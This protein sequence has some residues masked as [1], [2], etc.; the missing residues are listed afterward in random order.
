MNTPAA[1]SQQG[2]LFGHPSGLFTLFFAEMWERFSYYGMRALLILYMIK[3]FLGYGDTEAYAIY[4]AYTALVYMT[5]FFGGMIADRLIGQ[6]KAVVLGGAL[7]AA[8]HLFMRF[9]NET[10][11]F[12]ALALL[13]L[14]NGFFKPNISTIVGSLYPKGSAKRDSGFT[15]FY[16][17]INLGAAMSPLLC[18]YIGE[19]YGWHQ[20]FGLATFGMLIGLAVF[21]LP[22]LWS[23]ILIMLTSLVTAGMLFYFHADD[24]AS[25][26]INFSVAT[27]LLV[28]GVIATLAL[29]RGG[30]PKDAGLPAD[31]E[32]L[33]KPALLG[34]PAEWSVYIGTLALVPVFTLLVWGFA[35]F[36]SSTEERSLTNDDIGTAVDIA[37]EDRLSLAKG[38]L[39][40]GT[41]IS[42]EK[43]RNLEGHLLELDKI[44]I[45]KGLLDFK[46][47]EEKKEPVKVLAKSTLYK[48][49]KIIEDRKLTADDV[50]K[51]LQIKV[52]ENMVGGSLGKDAFTDEQFN[53]LRE[54]E[55]FYSSDST[56]PLVVTKEDIGKEISEEKGATGFIAILHVFLK[57]MSSPAGLILV[58][59]GIGALIF[60]LREMAG[61]G[62]IAKERM[63]VVLIMTFFSLLFWAIFEQAGSSVNLFTDRNVD[64]VNQVRLLTDEDIG[65]TLEIDLTQEQLGYEIDLA[66]TGDTIKPA[67]VFQFKDAGAASD[68]E[69]EQAGAAFTMD[70]LDR[71]RMRDK[72][73][74][75]YEKKRTLTAEDV[76]KTIPV[77]TGK[78]LVALMEKTGT[79]KENAA[80]RS[81]LLEALGPGD[82]PVT[83]LVVTTEFVG[84][85][86]S[87]IKELEKVKVLIKRSHVHP[88]PMGIAEQKHETKTGIY[89]SLNAAYILI[90]GLVFTALWGFLNSRG[91]EPS[92][93]VK[94]S[95]GLAQLGLGF[96]CF[97]LG[98]VESNDFGMVAVSWLYLGYLLQ[99]TGE[100]CLS[101]VG[102]SMVTKLSPGRLVSTVMG[103]W[104]LATA[105][106]AFLAAIIAQFTGVEDT[107][108]GG[109]AIPV[110]SETVD[111]YGG[112]F[113]ILAITGLVSGGICLVLSPLLK[114]W[115]HEG[116][117]DDGDD[118]PGGEDP[119]EMVDERPPATEGNEA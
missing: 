35:P 30:L 12:G 68:E 37:P 103:M 110:P 50:G 38:R 98:A 99:T 10:I 93:P 47:N 116:V 34:I 29:Q 25:M 1:S 119:P 83:N 64:R 113:G 71:W 4:G 84:L 31:P 107:G 70:R 96:A 63:Y 43:Q 65:K 20:G 108:D 23:Q 97:W 51:R 15:L 91:F 74:K 41:G 76:E 19:T 94:F 11:F 55:A 8:G 44:Q 101:P 86:I 114:R 3:G 112:V 46:F 73:S 54:E 40:D 18:S 115:M 16:I 81:S 117:D 85:E 102:L 72:L 28:A 60:I 79:D 22:T 80:L 53:E 87:E 5:P 61:L 100:L 92:T 14:G 17:G 66:L 118:H 52:R 58:L 75:G 95:L 78:L 21:V 90:L 42:E 104:F 32:K 27:A 33:R 2:T 45:N 7:M 9:E 13:I 69:K 49:G 111:I 39:F 88:V 24:T 62:K 89:Q 59:A 36:N 106:S 6:R 77:N 48:M 57:E 67:T 109:N 56:F 105:F 26:V 82:K